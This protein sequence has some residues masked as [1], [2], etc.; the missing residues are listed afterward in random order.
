MFS[1]EE[2]P[3]TISLGQCS[4]FTAEPLTFPEQTT[5]D[6]FDQDVDEEA[7]DLTSEDNC[8]PEDDPPSEELPEAQE[9]PPLPPPMPDLL[10]NQ[11]SEIIK[12]IERLQV[13]FIGFEIERF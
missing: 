10:E 4:E 12:R 7:P 13:F 11:P 1:E 3:S 6:T 2:Y 8:T 9:R 5:T